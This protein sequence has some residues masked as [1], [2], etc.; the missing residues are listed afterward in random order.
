MAR[1]RLTAAALAVT[2]AALVAA[3]PA[4]AA[5]SHHCASRDL[6]FPFQP[7]MAKTFG[8]HRLR[9]SGGSCATAHRIAK[10]FDH[11]FR[12]SQSENPPRHVHGWTFESLPF[13]AAQTFRLRGTEGARVVRFNYLV[14]NG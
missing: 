1:P 10:R 11:R 5:T 3:A 4:P 2:A 6:R 7:G 13:K 14:P 8:V 12:T 9:I